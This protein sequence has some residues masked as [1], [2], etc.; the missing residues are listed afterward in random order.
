MAST[1]L[2]TLVKV[3]NGEYRDW[4]GD[5]LLNMRAGALLESIAARPLFKEDLAGVKLGQCKVF[6]LPPVAA[7]DYR[8][9]EKMAG[10][11][12]NAVE[13]KLEDTVT[14]VWLGDKAL[15]RLYIRVDLP[16][17]AGELEL[18]GSRCN[19]TR[20]IERQIWFVFS[21]SSVFLC[22]ALNRTV[23]SILLLQLAQP[24][25]HQ[26]AL[27]EIRFFVCLTLMCSCECVCLLL[28]VA[29][30]GLGMHH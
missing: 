23:H 2:P 26:V 30:A 22:I 9:N 4:T 6:V 10:Y 16:P 12:S 13:L 11:N 8:D 19:E 27:L 3:G 28:Q 18:S 15:R 5:S 17:V 21:A 14:D 1:A 20:N 24:L 25:M 29:L 7:G